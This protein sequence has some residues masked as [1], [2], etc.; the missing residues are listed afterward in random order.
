[1]TAGDDLMKLRKSTTLYLLAIAVFI[2]AI[3]TTALTQNPPPTPPRTGV[4][5]KV[6][7]K[8]PKTGKANLPPNAEMGQGTTTERSIAVDP[9]V[10][11]SLCVHQGQIKING[12]ERSEVRAFVQ[13]GSR[14]GF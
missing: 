3:S 5:P 14:F 11:I 9:R 13:D 4:K 8:P 7:I 10:S 6:K 2:F 12:W 1:M